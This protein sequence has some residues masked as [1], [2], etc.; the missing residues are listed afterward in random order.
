MRPE[1]SYGL[2]F[3][4]STQKI[5][6]SVNSRVSDLEAA[7]LVKRQLTPFS[8][9]ATLSARRAV[10]SRWVINITVFNLSPVCARDILVMVSNIWDWA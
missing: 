1:L 10:E 8:I 5:Q 3:I 6:L 9:I 4:I 2:K 7:I